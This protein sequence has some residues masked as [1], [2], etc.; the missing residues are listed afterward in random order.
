MSSAPVLVNLATAVSVVV[1]LAM[2]PTTMNLPSDVSARSLALDVRFW[3]PT[4]ISASAMPS[5]AK[6]LS[7]TPLLLKRAAASRSNLPDHTLTTILPSG[8]STTPVAR[9][10]P[11]LAESK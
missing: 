11:L 2:V 5:P 8:W 4:L 1:P 9:T 7:S 6:V 10:R 3:L